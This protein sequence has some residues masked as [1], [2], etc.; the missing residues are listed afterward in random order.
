MK[1]SYVGIGV[2]MIQ[3]TSEEL[4]SKYL[5]HGPSMAQESSPQNRGEKK[6]GFR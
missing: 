4:N 2:N 3:T 6:F 1:A 5:T